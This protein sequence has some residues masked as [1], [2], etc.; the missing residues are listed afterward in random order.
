MNARFLENQAQLSAVSRVS[1]TT[2]PMRFVLLSLVV[3][4]LAA[5]AGGPPPPPPPQD[6][7]QAKAD[8]KAREEFARNLPKPPER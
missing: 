5:C 4:F 3:V 7:T 1:L 2:I 8:A 6:P